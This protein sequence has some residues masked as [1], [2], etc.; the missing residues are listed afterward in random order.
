MFL[1]V[2]Q[3][4][5]GSAGMWVSMSGYGYGSVGMY[6]WRMGMRVSMSKYECG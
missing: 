5:Y 6:G 3:Y 1:I 4:E 2:K